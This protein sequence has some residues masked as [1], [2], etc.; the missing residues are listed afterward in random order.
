MAKLIEELVIIKLSKLVKDRDE[1]TAVLAAD[2][3]ALLET[4][5]PAL[6]EEVIDDSNIVVELADID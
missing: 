3:R 4:T 2:K 1:G 6:L 5:L